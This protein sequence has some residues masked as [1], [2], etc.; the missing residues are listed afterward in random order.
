MSA[1]K[2]SIKRPSKGR[3]PFRGAVDGKPFSK[4]NQPSP[5][6]KSK[7]KKKSKLLTELLEL[8]FKGPTR[9][10]IKAAMAKYMGIPEE[11]LTVEDMMHGRQIERA[12]SK[13]NTFAYMAVMDRAFGKPKQITEEVGD[14]KIVVTIKK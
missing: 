11:E 9:G 5:E 8:T 12:I 3:V 2:T 7:G 14:K 13:S 6:A 10:K 1:K 4:D